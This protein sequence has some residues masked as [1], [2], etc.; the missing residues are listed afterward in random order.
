MKPGDLVQYVPS[1][2][3][4]FDNPFIHYGLVLKVDDQPAGYKR[5]V[6]NIRVRWFDHTDSQR[7]WYAQEELT[8]IS[9]CTDLK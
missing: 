1:A 4:A 6:C 3:E 2:I 5:D 9:K 8:V 7:D